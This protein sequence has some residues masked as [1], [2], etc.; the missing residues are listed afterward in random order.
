LQRRNAQINQ[1]G[2]GKSI[3]GRNDNGRTLRAGQ[4]LHFWGRVKIARN[5]QAGN[6]ATE[7]GLLSILPITESDQIARRD[8]T[9]HRFG[10]HSPDD[11]VAAHLSCRLADDEPAIEGSGNFPQRGRTIP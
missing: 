7:G 10:P 2:G 9:D 8:V 11:Y 6:L 4:L 1:P 3:V 5:N